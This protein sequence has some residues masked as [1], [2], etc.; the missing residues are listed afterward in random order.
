MYSF[1]GLVHSNKSY[2][3]LLREKLTK[4]LINK[5]NGVNVFPIHEYWADIGTQLDLERV[6]EDFINN[7]VNYGYES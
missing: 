7:G 1:S 4:M 3:K 6:R 5:E 2:H